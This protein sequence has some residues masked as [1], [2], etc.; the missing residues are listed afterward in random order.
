MNT[1]QVSFY[2]F[3]HCNLMFSS[4]E[5]EKRP[6]V[7]E[8][9]Y[10]PLLKLAENGYKLSIEASAITLEFVFEIDKSWIQKLKELIAEDK[11]EFIGCGYGQIIAPIVPYEINVRNLQIGQEVYERLLGIKPTTYLINE[12][13]FS[14]DLV[15][16][17][18]SAGIEN[19][20]LEWDNF[21]KFSNNVSRELS[22]RPIKLKDNDHNFLNVF[23]ADTVLFQKFQRHIHG[24]LDKPSYLQF[25]ASRNSGN[26]DQYMPLYSSDAEIFDFRPGRYKT[27]NALNTDEWGMI[28][29]LYMELQETSRF[30]FLK[31]I[32]QECGSQLPEVTFSSLIPIQ[33]KKQDKYNIYRWAVGGRNNLKVN[34]NC[35]KILAHYKAQKISDVSSWKELLFFW[36]SDFR[37]HITPSR[38]IEFESKMKNALSLIEC[39]VKEKEQPKEDPENISVL[40]LQNS[41]E[42]GTPFF[43]M[44]LNRNKGLTIE[45]FQRKSDN[46]KAIIGHI[47]HGTYDDIS[48]SNDYFSG[49]A[50]C[51]DNE[52][53][54]HTHLF[55]RNETIE[56]LSDRVMIKASN[57]C[58]GKFI[59]EDVIT[60]FEKYV[61]LHRVI[62]ILDM[63][64]NIIHPFIF[65]FLPDSRL[66]TLHYE[67]V[68]GGE[69]PQTY[70]ISR[71]SIH[72][73]QSRYQTISAVNGFSPTSGKL[74]VTTGNDEGHILFEIDNTESPLVASFQYEDEIGIGE[75][76]MPFC[77]LIFSAQEINDAYKGNNERDHKIETRLKIN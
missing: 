15:S 12:M 59:I 49:H 38:Y 56:K 57:T 60:I 20:I 14:V 42:I 9:C 61:E 34:A 3:Y 51:Y 74:S 64:L 70:F 39:P 75:N 76:K 26:G 7:I 53:K 77:R 4:I 37:T 40:L 46:N 69:T 63:S 54:Q 11:I 2:S 25:V 21:Y 68:C 27:E 52:R 55:N 58:N 71:S 35:Y 32:L 72:T 19:V 43:E 36:S 47:P 8:K 28:E 18:R 73:Q 6:E 67:T 24:E 31:E 44:R 50:I 66:D 41:I 65:T 62:T 22:Y 17:Y 13:A 1:N 45:S 48:Y 16:L 30:V 33:V 29:S 23:W 10:W 5:V